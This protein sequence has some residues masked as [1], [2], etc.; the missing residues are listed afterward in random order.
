MLS[1]LEVLS[2][3]EEEGFVGTEVAGK[4]LGP[5]MAPGLARPCGRRAQLRGRCFVCL[6]LRLGFGPVRKALL[7]IRLMLAENLGR[8]PRQPGSLRASRAGTFLETGSFR[9]ETT[10]NEAEEAQEG[11]GSEVWDLVAG[12]LLVWLVRY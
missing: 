2:S 5:R 10:G 11:L 4:S 12:E 7:L 1:Y 9:G 3:G 6:P 8:W